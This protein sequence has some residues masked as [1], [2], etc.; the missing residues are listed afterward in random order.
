[1]YK[2]ECHYDPD[3]ESRRS[4]SGSTSAASAGTKRDVSATTSSNSDAVSSAEFIIQALRNLPEDEV[5][6]FV[7]HVRKD[8]NLGIP[9]LADSWRKTVTI[10]PSTSSEIRSLENDLSVLL[11]KP[12]LTQTG[13]SR[14]FGHSASLG[15]VPEDENFGGGRLGASNLH[16]ERKGTT[17]TNVTTDLAFVERLFQLYF[18]WSHPFYV[19]FSRECFYMDFRA[20]RDK[21]CSPLLVNAICAYACH[22]TDDPAGR[23]DPANFRSAGDH[24]F[25]EAKRLLFEDEAPSLTTTQALCVMSMREPSTGRDTSGFN[26]IGRCMR[27]CVELG[28]HLNNSASPALRLTPSEIEVRKVTFWGCFT[29]D[30]YV[31]H[32]L[33][34]LFLTKVPQ[35]LVHLHGSHSPTSASRHYPRQAHPRRN[36]WPS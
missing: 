34:R 25:A 3:S 32:Y 6:D 29:V 33:V 10:A 36:W 24:F 28:L 22:L 9:A 8:P 14:H 4:K 20:G 2:T 16:V 5:R 30:T 15:L 21:Y 27:M 35:G 31:N 7:S 23:T 12:A 1:V 13:Q 18:M 17:W 26:Y 11:G 19:L